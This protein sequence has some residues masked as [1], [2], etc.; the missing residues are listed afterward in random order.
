VPK[1]PRDRVRKRARLNAGSGVDDHSGGFVD[2]S[3]YSSSKTMSSGM[4]SLEP[5]AG[6]SVMSIVD[7]VACPQFIRRLSFFFIDEHIAVL[8]LSLQTRARPAFN[9]F[10]RNASRRLP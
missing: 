5:A 7:L 8:D 3:E 2:D 10:A 4:F 1:L 6:S 9:V